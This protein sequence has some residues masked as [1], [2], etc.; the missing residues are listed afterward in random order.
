MNGKKILG[1]IVLAA[2]LF[3]LLQ[4]G[5]SFTKNKETAS[6]GPLEFSVKKKEKVALPPWVGIVG[7]VGGVALLV[8]P[9]RK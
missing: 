2:G 9:S 3:I 7:I 8:L 4:G 1:L 5:F 6:L